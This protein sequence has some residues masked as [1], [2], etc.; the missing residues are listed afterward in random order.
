MAESAVLHRLPTCGLLNLRGADVDCSRVVGVALPRAPCTFTVHGDAAAYW[1]G[2]DEWLLAVPG[3]A[4]VELEG[5]LTGVT[6]VG[7]V[8]D[9]SSGYVRYDLSGPRA[10]QV[11]MKASPY[12]FDQRVFA[13]GRCAQTVFAKTTALIARRGS[14]SFRLLVRRSYADYVEQWIADAASE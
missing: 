13:L 6:G 3:G 9:V 1:L 14:E 11:L 2:P 5:I 10:V 7:A 8:V 4:R 12:D